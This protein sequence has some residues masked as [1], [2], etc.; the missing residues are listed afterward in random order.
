VVAGS[1]AKVIKAVADL[2]CP[3][4]FFERPYTWPPYQEESSSS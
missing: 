1:P 2:A 3:P 4:G